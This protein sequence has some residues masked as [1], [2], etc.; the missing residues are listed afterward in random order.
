MDDRSKS[1][2]T[3]AHSCTQIE[4]TNP[5]TFALLQAVVKFT[6]ISQDATCHCYFL[7]ANLTS[8]TTTTHQNQGSG[9]LYCASDS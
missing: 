5:Y 3:A 1:H 7:A 4:V 8:T 6:K 9:A 2:A